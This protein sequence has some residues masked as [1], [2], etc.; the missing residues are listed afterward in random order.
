MMAKDPVFPSIAIKKP[1]MAWPVTESPSQIPCPHV[2]AFWIDFFGT[3]ADKMVPNVGPV[4][5]L[6]MPVKNMAKYM[7]NAIQFLLNCPAVKLVESN[8]KNRAQVK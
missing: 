4:N 2:V 5:D 8:S 1:T 7:L 6:K 3:I